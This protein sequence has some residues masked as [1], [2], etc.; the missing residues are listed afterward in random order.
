MTEQDHTRKKESGSHL[1]LELLSGYTAGQLSDAEEEKIAQHLSTCTA[2][3]LEI[4]RLERFA[5]IDTD[6]DLLTEAEWEQA[7]RQ[8]DK[9]Y[10]KIIRPAVSESN[11]TASSKPTLAVVRR[12]RA[13]NV[14]RWA[15]PLAAAAVLV[16]VMLN[17]NTG[18]GPEAP[19]DIRNVG[20]DPVRGDNTVQIDII[21]KSP[22]GELTAGPERFVWQAPDSLE[23]FSLEIFTPA[24]ELVFRH[25]HIQQHTFAVTDSLLSL[26]ERQQ[27]YLW[28]V[29][30]YT[31]IEETTASEN[32]WFKIVALKS[33]G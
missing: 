31:G 20:L 17:L 10:E 12:W 28:S 24:L 32:G 7:E 15:T 29:Q 18:T 14:W 8:L 5:S 21:L 2:C 19:P 11:Q 9:V 26:F 13:Q 3:S 1:D 22:S 6:Q 30:G 4:K 27:I 16:F 33:D 23:F 25:D